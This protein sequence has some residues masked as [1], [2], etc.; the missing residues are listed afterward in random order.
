VARVKLVMKPSDFPGTPDEATKKGL[1]ELFAHMFPGNANPEIPGNHAAFGTVA[2]DPG[3]A[4]RLI[5]LSDYIVRE[6]PWTSQRADLREVAI[7]ALNLH[8]KCDFSF[9]AHFRPGQAN[10]IR[11]E[12]QAALPFWRTANVFNDEQRLVIEYTFAVVT[13]DVPGE[14]FARVVE[15]FGEQ[16]AVEFTVGIAW[17]SFWAMLINATRTDFDFGYGNPAV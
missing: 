8:F 2:R 9:Q 17:W 4:L 5:K 11:L 16:G 7:Q 13:G 6:M 12:Q 14:L 1:D 3:L 10:G 15:R